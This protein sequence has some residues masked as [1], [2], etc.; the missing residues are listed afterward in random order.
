MKTVFVNSLINLLEKIKSKSKITKFEEKYIM[1][2][3]TPIYFDSMEEKLHFSL[4]KEKNSVYLEFRSSEIY[5]DAKVL[6][7]EPSTIDYKTILPIII[8]SEKENIKIL[9]MFLITE[10]KDKVNKKE[11]IEQLVDIHLHPNID[12]VA[13]KEVF[14]KSIQYL[15]KYLKDKK[16]K[17][18][19]TN[20]HIQIKYTLK[21][22]DKLTTFTFKKDNIKKDST[23]LFEG[24]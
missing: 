24:I 1:L 2:D 7:I 14:E 10:N 18:S 22:I 19:F 11:F 16:N 4:K 8:P 3:K 13:L 9:L 21:D 6:G 5:V 17:I 12:K 20:D 23:K 15:E